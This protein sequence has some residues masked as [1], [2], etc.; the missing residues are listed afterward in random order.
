MALLPDGFADLLPFVAQWAKDDVQERHRQRFAA[1][2]DGV[3][4][5]YDALAPRATDMMAYLDTVPLDDMPEEAANLYKLLMAL[6]HVT[7]SVEHHGEL[8]PPGTAFNPAVQIV[9]GPAPA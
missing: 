2:M 8:A 5:F 7:L 6:A 3:Q 4:A 1:G 9:R